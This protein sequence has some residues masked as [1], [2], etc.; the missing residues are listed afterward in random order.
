MIETTCPLG[1]GEGAAA[2]V[3]LHCSLMMI[4]GGDCDTH[5]GSIREEWELFN[6]EE[7]EKFP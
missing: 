7:V 3:E 1:R 4:S 5:A 6:P 2:E